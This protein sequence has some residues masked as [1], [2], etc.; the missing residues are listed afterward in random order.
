M[1][2]TDVEAATIPPYPVAL[3]IDYPER[4]SR[5]KTLLRFFLL[6]PLFIVSVLALYA[7]M[8]VAVVS[9]IAILVRGRIPA[10]M[11]DAQVA[12]AR[13]SVRVYSYSLLLTDAYPPFDGEHPVSL[14]IQYPDRVSRRRLVVWKYVTSLP[15]LFVLQFLWL[16]ALVCTIIA[17][18][19]I[20]IVGRF[21]KGMH[22]FVAGVLRW[23]TRVHAYLFSL[24]DEYPPFSLSATAG[25]A[26]R[27]TYVVGS[28]IGC[29][30]AAAWIATA[31]TFS[32]L[33]RETVRVTVPYDD[34]QAGV[35]SAWRTEVEVRDVG[36][37]IVTVT[38][39]ETDFPL[40]L[41]GEDRRLVGFEFLLD[42]RSGHTRYVNED[43]FRLKD[44][45]GD[46]H[47]PEIVVAGGR[48]PE[49]K[50]GDGVEVHVVA[51]FEIDEDAEPAEIEYTTHFLEGK[52]VIYDFE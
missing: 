44:S 16:A 1:V 46:W 9:W 47:H 28:V 37:S 27:D 6:I 51:V 12:V 19:A 22:G 34:L 15:H 38:D 21:P 33:G 25:P 5:W 32:I 50:F 13:W 43:D 31:V 20:L 45:E 3:E 23:Q 11:F 36:I 17:W 14:E 18:F 2:L 48:I 40:L 52:R 42:N 4:Q 7:G 29:L 49:V 24:R 26:G 10:W 30:L 35:I 8:L 41:P 39:P